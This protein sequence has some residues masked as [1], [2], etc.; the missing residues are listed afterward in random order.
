MVH[1]TQLLPC[2]RV[3]DVCHGNRQGNESAGSA[4]I[5]SALPAPNRWASI[6]ITYVAEV[7]PF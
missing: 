3:G 2:G 7:Q 5:D 1:A 4:K 6:Y